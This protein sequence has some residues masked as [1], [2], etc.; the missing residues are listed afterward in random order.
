MASV[1]SKNVVGVNLMVVSST[2]IGGV[3]GTYWFAGLK[4]AG[5]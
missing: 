1:A 4:R 2:E 5:G 3:D